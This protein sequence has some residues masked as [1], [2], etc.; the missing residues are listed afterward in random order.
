MF[1]DRGNETATVI[2][3]NIFYSIWVNYHNKK[4]LVK[5]VYEDIIS[6]LFPHYKQLEKNWS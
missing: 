6:I 3:L 2:R 1:F 4:A 5:V